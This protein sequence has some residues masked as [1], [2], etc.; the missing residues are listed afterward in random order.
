MRPYRCVK[1]AQGHRTADCPKTDRNTPAKC[2]LCFGAHP[3]NYKGCDVYKEILARKSNKQ[4]HIRNRATT[5]NIDN[6]QM[7]VDCIPVANKGGQ[8]P[9]KPLQPATHSEGKTNLNTK[10]RPSYAEI[11]RTNQ[12][13]VI[14]DTTTP[15][16]TEEMLLK[17]AEKF[18]LILQQMSTL[19]NLITTLV[20]KI[21]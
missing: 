20:A 15:N 8:V 18:D 3:A 7:P 6:Q 16:K 17:Q 9:R 14:M 11:L 4:S 1:C 5:T 2:A 12:N 13:T 21:S 10:K 19:I